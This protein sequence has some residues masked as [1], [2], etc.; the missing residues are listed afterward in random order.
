MW[1]Y[2]QV[3]EEAVGKR[4][5]VVEEFLASLGLM[6]VDMTKYASYCGR[7]VLKNESGYFRVDKVSYETKPFLVIE[8]AEN[9]SSVLDDTME[10]VDPFPFDLPDDEIM[11]LLENMVTN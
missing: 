3:T 5:Q 2:T 6:E 9:I 10:D 11:E 4:I 1:R 7:T 8:W